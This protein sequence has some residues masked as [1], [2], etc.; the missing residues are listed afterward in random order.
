M[1]RIIQPTNQIDAQIKLPGSKYVANRLVPLC[2]LASSRS[3]LTNLV[4]NDDINHAIDGLGQLGYQ[5]NRIEGGLEV[6][7]R[8]QALAEAATIYTAHSGTFSRFVAA[9]AALE[10]VPVTINC[11]EKM[12][13]RPMQE[14]FETLRALS[15]DV[16]SPNECLPAIITGSLK[17]AQCRLD[18]SR[19]SQYLSAL[20]IVAPF[21]KDGLIIEL[22][23]ELVS[24]AYVDMTIQLMSKMGVEVIEEGHCFIVK[25]GQV[26]QGIDYDIPCDPVSSTYFMG[27]AAIAS[28]RIKIKDFDFDSTQGEARFYQVLEKMGVKVSK[29]NDAL[30]I[31]SN[32]VLNG[33]EVDMGGMPD[34]VQ[35]LAVVACFAEGKTRINNIAHLAYKES[36][37]I[38]DT[39]TELRKVGVTVNSGLDF[40]EIEGLGRETEL[41]KGAKIETHEDHRMAMSMALL[42]IKIPEIEVLNA[43]V[44]AKSF[45]TFWKAMESI[46]VNSLEIS[47]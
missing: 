43:E 19:S 42:G 38:E 34:A 3:Q 37:R 45:P 30:V 8:S 25:P 12:A 40:L 15:V 10:T 5:F 33:V 26:Y 41:L 44:V 20:L 16:D 46:G 18:A 2:A 27:A 47:G 36:N 31:Q 1:Q 11:S 35:T 21:L 32:G 4:E 13:T 24:R 39:A 14:L 29:N 23:G 6:L 7:P 9:I 22:E 17:G 28:G